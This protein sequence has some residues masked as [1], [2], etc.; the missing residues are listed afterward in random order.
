M[1]TNKNNS[2]SVQVAP[3]QKIIEIANKCANKVWGGSW[4]YAIKVVKLGQNGATIKLCDGNKG[5]YTIEIEGGSVV[6]IQLHNKVKALGL[7]DLW[8]INGIDGCADEITEISY[9]VE[10]A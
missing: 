7:T 10:V 9:E 6:Y 2:Q 3:E 1:K 4:N 8:F 5:M